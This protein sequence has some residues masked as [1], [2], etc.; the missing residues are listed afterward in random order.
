MCCTGYAEIW[1]AV[2]S[3]H[4][5]LVGKDLALTRPSLKNLHYHIDLK[6][7]TQEILSV[8]YN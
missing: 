4:I 5:L 1:T 3:Q 8:E 7:V 2:S 6:V